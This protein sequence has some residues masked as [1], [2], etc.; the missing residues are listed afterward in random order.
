[1]DGLDDADAAEQRLPDVAAAE[2]GA[3]VSPHA[4]ATNDATVHEPGVEQDDLEEDGHAEQDQSSFRQR[5][6]AR[7][8]QTSNDRAVRADL[9]QGKTMHTKAVHYR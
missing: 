7:R 3:G 1:M 5:D 9:I 6:S 4:P 2:S 8:A